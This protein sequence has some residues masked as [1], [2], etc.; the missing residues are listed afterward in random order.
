MKVPRNLLKVQRKI[1]EYSEFSLCQ[2]AR[3]SKRIDKTV[4][5]I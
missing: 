1:L 5:C 2:V 4:V 3:S